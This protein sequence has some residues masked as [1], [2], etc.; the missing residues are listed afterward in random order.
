[1]INSCVPL[2]LHGGCPKNDSVFFLIGQDPLEEITRMLISIQN[3]GTSGI[4]MK[5]LG[6]HR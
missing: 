5:N 1:M 3:P 6:E 4:D 2:T